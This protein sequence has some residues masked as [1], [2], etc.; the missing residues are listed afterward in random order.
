MKR[1]FVLTV[2]TLVF[3]AANAQK[4]GG[5]TVFGT[6]YQGDTIPLS[7]L[8]PVIVKGYISPL[9]PE[10]Q[11]KYSKLIR[12]V[13]K[14]Y[15]IAKDAQQLFNAYSA[16]ID[17][18]VNEAQ[19]NKIKKQ[20]YT[21]VKNKFT[22]RSKSL[23]KDQSKLLSK[24]IYR[25]TGY[26]SYNLIKTFGGG[27]KATM[28]AATTKAM[29]INLKGTFDAQNNEEDRMIERIIYCIEAGKL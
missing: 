29:G 28:A 22:D 25:Q 7:Y 14:T 20:A 23:N 12:N 11:R 3:F 17:K 5:I 8:E 21:D 18:S 15:P 10:E 1:I 16:M 27:V 4:E 13:K 9:T 24:L 6:I 19:I 26:S 2:L